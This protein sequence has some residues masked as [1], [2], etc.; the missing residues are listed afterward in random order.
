M[1][2]RLSFWLLILN[3]P[4]QGEDV[5]SSLWLPSMAE[6]GCLSSLPCLLPSTGSLLSGHLDLCNASSSK[7]FC[8][9]LIEGIL[10][11]SLLIPYSFFT[12]PLPSLVTVLI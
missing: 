1:E 4:D 8:H 6:G 2:T 11:T 7:A 3:K 12:S 9:Y 5:A 10:L